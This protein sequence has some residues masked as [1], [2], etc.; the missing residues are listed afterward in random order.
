MSAKLIFSHKDIIAGCI[1]EVVIWHLLR[2]VAGCNHRFKYR[3]YFGGQD[4]TCLV[5]YDNERGKGD[6]RHCADHEQPYI[7]TGIDQLLVDFDNDIKR[8]LGADYEKL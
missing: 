7:F 5:R 4:G 1:R 6:H 2:P 8:I 3:F